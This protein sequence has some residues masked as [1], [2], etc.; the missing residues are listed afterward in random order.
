M[1]TLQTLRL[2][3]ERALHLGGYGCADIERLLFDYVQGELSPEI[4]AKL[5]K[6]LRACAPCMEYLET[7]RRTIR[8]THDHG[9]PEMEMPP[10]LHHRLK[11]FIAQNPNLR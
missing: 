9:L 10:E 5:D 4:S 1:T 2:L 3:V 11:E 6:H 8:A 7:Y